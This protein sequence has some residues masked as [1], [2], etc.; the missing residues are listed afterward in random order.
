M[1]LMHFT[2]DNEKNESINAILA[3]VGY[4]HCIAIILSTVIRLVKAITVAVKRKDA[5]AS[6]SD[7]A[8]DATDA[9]VEETVA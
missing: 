5:Q 8:E 2:N 6:A 1:K 4:V 3:V 7:I 9:A